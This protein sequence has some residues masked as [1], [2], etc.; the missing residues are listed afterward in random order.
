MTTAVYQYA[1]PNPYPAMLPPPSLLLG[2]GPGDNNGDNGFLGWYPGQDRTVSQVLEWLQDPNKK[3]LCATLPTGSGKSLV[4]AITS[5]MSGM[6]SAVLTNTKGLQD[7]FVSEFGKIGFQD[8]RGQ[9]SYPCILLPE[10]GLRVDEGPCHAGMTCPYRDSTCIYYHELGKA[11]RSKFVITNYSF[12]LA[13][14]H[15]YAQRGGGIGRFGL[16]VMDEADQAFKAIE[17]YLTTHL[18]AEECKQAG[19]RLPTGDRLPQAW[20]D[21]K[22]WAH[23]QLPRAEA[24]ER[25]TKQGLPSEA[26]NS[27][28]YDKSTQAKMERVRVVQGVVRKLELLRSSVG[29]WVW[30]TT[31]GGRQGGGFGFLFTPIWP[32]EYANLV[33][34]QAE[35]VLVMSATLTPKTADL[36][37]IPEEDR[38]WIEVDSS[39]PP[40]NTPIQHIKTV[41]VNHRSSDIDMRSWANK[42]DQIIDRRL[43]RKGL[44]LPVSYQRGEFL[45]AMSRHSRIMITHQPGE[46]L[47]AVRFW[48][49]SP[50]P[51]VLVSPSVTRGWDFPGDLCRYIVIAKIPFPDTRDP[52]VAARKDGDPDFSGFEIMQTLVQEAGRGTRSP[53]DWC[54]VFVTDGNWGH[55]WMNNSQHAPEFFRKRL[56]KQTD[57]IPDPPP[58]TGPVPVFRR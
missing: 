42:I 55:V 2:L 43:D 31:G 21:W 10:A 3:F 58:L 37:G 16:V 44:V 24:A 49:D 50:S 1:R 4:S 33:F 26:E 11:S 56:R 23:E 25:R 15:T 47:S 51:S 29:D 30:K 18:S 53:D 35:K 9:S 8:M 41:R 20:L 14:A 28:N 48:H 54:E 27:Q 12:W 19:V 34:G 38:T 39:Y 7:Q 52:V 13:Q 17:S 46:V 45:A 36:L 6:R 5:V 40:G 32:G 57:L 22:H